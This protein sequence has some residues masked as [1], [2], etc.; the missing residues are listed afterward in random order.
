MSRML[1]CLLFILN[2]SESVIVFVT[3]V[4]ISFIEWSVVIVVGIRADK[5]GTGETRL[6]EEFSVAV[7]GGGEY[8]VAVSLFDGLMPI[9]F[10]ELM[11]RDQTRRSAM[12]RIFLRMSSVEFWHLYKTATV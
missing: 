1:V 5:D 9:T 12:C 3:L 4:S 2:W 10:C 11:K 7:V 8:C 6:V